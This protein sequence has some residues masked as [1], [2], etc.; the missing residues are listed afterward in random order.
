[1]K[2][3]LRNDEYL[4][5]DLIEYRHLFHKYAKFSLFKTKSLMHMAYFMSITPVTGLNT[6]NN[7]LRL[8]KV[9]IP[10]DGKYV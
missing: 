10:V 2:S 5:T 6:I 3:F 4:P 8:F 9:Q 7:I 1:M